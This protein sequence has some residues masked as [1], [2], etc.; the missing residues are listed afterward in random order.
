MPHTKKPKVKIKRVKT[1]LGWAYRTYMATTLTPD[2]ARDDAA[3]MLTSYEWM[4]SRSK[5]DGAIAVTFGRLSFLSQC[6]VSWSVHRPQDCCWC[7]VRF[8]PKADM[9]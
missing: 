2:A 5:A 3:R 9:S 1:S 7:D 4:A 6:P 8:W